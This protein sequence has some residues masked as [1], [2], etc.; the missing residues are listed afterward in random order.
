MACAALPKSQRL[1]I[2]IKTNI[3]FVTAGGAVGIQYG[4]IL[5]KLPAALIFLF[6]FSSGKKKFKKLVLLRK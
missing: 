1:M 5:A 6:L 2:T 3:C 4:L